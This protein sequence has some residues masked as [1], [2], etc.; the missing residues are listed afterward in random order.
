MPRKKVVK[1]RKP[2]K[3]PEYCG[4]QIEEIGAQ[5]VASPYSS[6]RKVFYHCRFADRSFKM[7][8]EEVLKGFV[9]QSK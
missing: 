5:H 9:K 4:R 6:N 1:K 2:K 3:L 8:P 7:V